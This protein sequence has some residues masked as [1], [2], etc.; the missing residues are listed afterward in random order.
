[1]A[2][3]EKYKNKNKNKNKNKKQN[4]RLAIFFRQFLYD[5]AY[6]YR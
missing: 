5:T 6:D 2:K 1:L 4:K 3:I